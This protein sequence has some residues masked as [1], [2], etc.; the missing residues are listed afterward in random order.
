[1]KLRLE[2]RKG[3]WAEK[4]SKVLWSY[5]TTVRNSTGETPFALA[6]GSEAVVP[7]EVGL[8]SA[9]IEVFDAPSN[10]EELRLNLDL[11]EEKR[12]ASNLALAEYQQWMKRHYDSRVKPRR[13]KTGDLVL[14]KV[15]QKRG[16]LEPTWEGPYRIGGEKRPETYILADLEGKQLHYPWHAQHLRV[17]YH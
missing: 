10:N 6:F 2:G 13:F 7:V 3:R 15:I 11:L 8:P 14:Q 16:A 5:R 17:Y 4:L 9:R 12:E 1:M